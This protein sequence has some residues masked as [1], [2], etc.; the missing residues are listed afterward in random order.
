[1]ETSEIRI[2]VYNPA[3]EGS[4]GVY[5]L[6]RGTNTGK[7]QKMPSCNSYAIYAPIELL[8]LVEA[9]ANILFQSNRLRPYLHGSCIEF[10][11]IQTYRALFVDLWQTITPEVIARVAKQLELLEQYASSLQLQLKKVVSLYGAVASS[12]LR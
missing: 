12:A 11:R 1:M 9:T 8:P 6:S 5:V 2:V 4:Q 3:Q 10:V 7:V